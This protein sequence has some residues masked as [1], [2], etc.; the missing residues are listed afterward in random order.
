MDNEKKLKA[1]EEKF[2]IIQKYNNKLINRSEKEL[3]RRLKGMNE[4][5]AQ[6]EK[7]TKTFLTKTEYELKIAI[8]E[9]DIKSLSKLV[10]IGVGIILVLEL[11]LKLLF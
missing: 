2:T 6:L 1:L 10:Y 7:Q 5:R 8:L 9:R 11:I 4:F 3:E